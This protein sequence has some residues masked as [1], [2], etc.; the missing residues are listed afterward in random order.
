MSLLFAYLLGRISKQS[1]SLMGVDVSDEALELAEINRQ[2]VLQQ[3]MEEGGSS[4]AIKAL[5]N[6]RYN[7][8]NIL[9]KDHYPGQ[10]RRDKEISTAPLLQDLLMAQ[11]YDIILS[12]PPYICPQ[13]HQHLDTSV[14][15]YEPNLALVPPMPLEPKIHPGDTF[16]PRLLEIGEDVNAKLLFMEVGDLE[17]AER[18]ADMATSHPYWTG[19]VQIW[20][21][22]L[23]NASTAELGEVNRPFKT[24]N[25]TLVPVIGNGEGRTVISW[26]HEA[27]DWL[28]I[29][30]T[31]AK[32]PSKARQ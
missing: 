3:V 6:L 18:V 8:A 22:D 1:A 5:E 16:Y 29:F 31:G 13:A 14:R 27:R 12:N 2:Q 11:S 17:Q 32:N 20:R 19:G 28:D 25:G 7:K 23:S 30:D 9:D 15:E 21:D 10:D 24:S 26:T 4:H